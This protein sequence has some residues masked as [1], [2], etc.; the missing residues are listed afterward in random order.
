[1]DDLTNGILD[2]LS[3]FQELQ[4]V[5]EEMSYPRQQRLRKELLTYLED[6]A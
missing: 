5:I 6:N 1:M 2:I 3:K 4:D